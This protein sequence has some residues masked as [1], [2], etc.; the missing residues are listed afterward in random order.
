MDE[1]R[2]PVILRLQTEGT[3]LQRVQEQAAGPRYLPPAWVQLLGRSPADVTDEE[4]ALQLGE[5]ADQARAW[6]DHQAE[7]SG[8]SR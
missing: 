6:A 2:R 4:H 3:A 7:R 5:H 8:W 1:D